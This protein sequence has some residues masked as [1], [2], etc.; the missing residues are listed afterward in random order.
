MFKYNKP[1]E[2]AADPVRTVGAVSETFVKFEVGQ[3]YSA[4][5][6]AENGQK[7]YRAK[8]THTAT[9][10]I[11]DNW[12]PLPALPSKGGRTAIFRSKFENTVSTLPYGTTLLTIQDVVDFLLGYGKYQT[13]IGFT[14]DTFNRELEQVENWDLTT[15]EFLFWTTQNW[16][17]GA[18]ITLSPSAQELN[19]KREYA[20]VDDIFDPFY[21]CLLY[22]SPSP[23]DRT[24]SRMP[25]SA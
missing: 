4:G 10:F 12:T 3:T 1:L 20:V 24:R 22:T 25:S 23:R 14:F 8:V 19:F 18:L 11:E 15:R 9:A 21:D 5:T 2:V 6:L 7:Y 16:Q 17:E 13:S